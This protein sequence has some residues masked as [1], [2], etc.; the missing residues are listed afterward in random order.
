ML[1]KRGSTRWRASPTGSAPGLGRGYWTVWCAGTV[2]FVGDGFT[3][4]A[5]P[6]LAISLTSDA[7]LISGIEALLMAGWLLLGL[8]S[9]VVADQADRLRIMGRVDALRML[10]MAG[11]VAAVLTGVITMP[12]LLV[13]ALMLGLASPFFDNASSSVVPDLVPAAMLEKA[14]A[15]NQVP[16]MVATNLIGPPLGALL[17]ALSHPA[18]FLLDAVSFAVSALVL[19]RLARRRRPRGPAVASAAGPG[20]WQLLRVGM[21]YLAHHGTLRTLAV[22][23]GLMNAVAGGLM[24]VLVLYA[25]RTLELP[26]QGYGWL[27]ATFAAGGLI[28][29]M[30]ATGLVRRGGARTCAIGSLLAFALVVALLGAVPLLVAV[31]PLLMLAGVSSVVWN[32]VTIS[33]RQ[34][35]VP[36]NLLGRVT[37]AYSVILF[38]GMPAGAVLA[39]LLTHSIGVTHTYLTGGLTLLVVA[40]VITP[41]LRHMPTRATAG[42]PAQ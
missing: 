16:M 8:V 1:N 31:I 25:T 5:L 24:A 32:V 36:S 22:A 39:G 17:F 4:G 6:L 15:L 38:L 7:R 11:L 20:P 29:S 13:V 18:P 14:N 35:E 2:S 27:I 42:V 23:G 33:Y 12:V 21:R 41:L 9:G 26:G 40:L 30:L 28:G 19:L 10:I 34:R 37:S 3:I